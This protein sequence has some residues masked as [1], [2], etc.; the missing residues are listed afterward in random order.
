MSTAGATLKLAAF[1]AGGA[2]GGHLVPTLGTGT[3]IV[4]VG[5]VQL[6]GA[7]AGWLTTRSAV[8]G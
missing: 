7:G 8:Q 5:L 1:A 4:V 6:A 3:A 2:L